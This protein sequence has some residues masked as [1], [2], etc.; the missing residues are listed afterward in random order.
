MRATLLVSAFA[1]ASAGSNWPP[2]AYA[3]AKAVLAKMNLTH[4]IL[5]THGSG[6][7]YVGDTP[8]ITLPDG[9]VI[10]AIHEHDGPQVI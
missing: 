1:L 8:S 2:A 10:P 9:T 4:K 7:A 6:G 5:M 3:S